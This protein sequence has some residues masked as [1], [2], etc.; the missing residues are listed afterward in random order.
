MQIALGFRAHSGWAAVVGVAGAVEAPRVVDRRR[1]SIA[2]VECP[3]SKQ[4]Y[5][6]AAELPLAQAEAIVNKA[7]NSSRALALE[8]I[9][10]TVT[11]LR[12]RGHRVVGCAVLTGSGK[13]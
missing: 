7:I 10:A 8:A 12:A 2:D 13:P 4:P 11:E 6:A 3:T 5:H 9:S 1:I